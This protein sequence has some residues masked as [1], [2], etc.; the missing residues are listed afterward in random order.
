MRFRA[1]VRVRVGCARGLRSWLSSMVAVVEQPG[2]W[3]RD[4]EAVRGRE[5]WRARAL[6]L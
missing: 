3:V 6:G 5:S 1:R 2:D 4:R